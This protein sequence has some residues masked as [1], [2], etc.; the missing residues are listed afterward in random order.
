MR[1]VCSPDQALRIGLQQRIDQRAQVGVARVRARQSVGC[2][3]FHPGAFFFQQAAQA[4]EARAL[5]QFRHRVVAHVVHDHL[6]A[7]VGHLL[8]QLGCLLQVNQQLQM[9]AMR[10]NF[11]HQGVHGN[12]ARSACIE[13]IDS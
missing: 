3:K 13:G 12:Q 6:H 1:P 8:G 7:K 10:T 4:C 5:Q 11:I 9:P 2:R